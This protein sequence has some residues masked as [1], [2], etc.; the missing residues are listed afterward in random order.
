MHCKVLADFACVVAS[1]G[2]FLDKLMSWLIPLF[3]VLHLLAAVAWV[4]G[5]LFAHTALRPSAMA[6]EPPMR[7]ALWNRVFSRFFP[8]VWVCVVTLLVT[9]H[10]LTGMGAGTGSLSVMTMTAI[11][12]VMAALF[13][14][15]YL[16][17]YAE[18]RICLAAG[19]IP[20]AAAAQN[21]IRQIVAINLVL[22]LI[23]C[24]LGVLARFFG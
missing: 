13:T 22:G 1:I 12:W 11:A 20:G 3:L 14:Y 9:G 10:G 4:G 17:P 15:L 21:V 2:H 24:T 8:L 16:R 6:L 5:M 7:L 18:L 23:T 19:N